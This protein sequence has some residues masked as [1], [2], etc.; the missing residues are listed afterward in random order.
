M[1]DGQTLPHTHCPLAGWLAAW[2]LPSF[3]SLYRWALGKHGLIDPGEWLVELIFDFYIL[4]IE[5]VSD[6]RRL[7]S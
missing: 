7:S 6:D 4:Y 2:S 5:G 3:K 1:R